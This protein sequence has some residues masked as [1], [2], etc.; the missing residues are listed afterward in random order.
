MLYGYQQGHLWLGDQVLAIIA[1]VQLKNLLQVFRMLPSFLHS[2]FQNNDTF[3]F[4]CPFNAYYLIEFQL[5]L[6]IHLTIS[7]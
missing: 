5:E 2:M 6:S 1:S 3:H 7:K 4:Y